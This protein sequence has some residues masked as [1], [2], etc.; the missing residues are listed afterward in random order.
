M[1][2]VTHRRTQSHIE[3]ALPVDLSLADLTVYDR[4]GC[5]AKHGPVIDVNSVK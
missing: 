3:C 4:I 5:A 1:P 2:R